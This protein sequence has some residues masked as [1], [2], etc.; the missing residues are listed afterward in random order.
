[1]DEVDQEFPPLWE[2]AASNGLKTGVFGSLLTHEMPKSLENYAFYVPEVFAN[3][4]STHPSYLS[5]FQGF[6]LAMSRA[7]ARNV[8]KKIDWSSAR[9]F[10]TKSFDLGLTLRTSLDIG[11]QLISEQLNSHHKTRRRTYQSTLGFDIFMKQLQ[12]FKPDLVTFFTNHVAATMHRYW[13]ASFP[14][15]YSDFQLLPTWVST[16][17]DEID[18]AMHKTDEMLARLVNFVNQNSEYALY[19]IT[20]MGQAAFQAKPT[21]AFL[22]IADLPKFMARLGV[23][24]SE[25]EQRPAMAPHYSVVVTPNKLDRL[26]DRSSKLMMNGKPIEFRERE[27]G[28][29]HIDFMY[30]GY[31]GPASVELDGVKI[32]FA[33]IGI[34]NTEHEDGV[35]LTADHI[36]QGVMLIY[37]LKQTTSNRE[38]TQI[39]TLDITPSILDNF[40]I[41]IPDYMNRT[42]NLIAA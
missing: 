18:F 21:K 20:S 9:E 42:P 5:S 38:R 22:T 41:S 7:S 1:L 35:Y 13:A 23:E 40:S 16:F 11:G 26:R 31:Q 36:P 12:I 2:L 32:S 29:F 28:F 25:Y 19:V 27:D 37:N 17:R 39:S 15:D 30:Q 14:N 33:E 24:A 34:V 10:V 3:E 4:A 6:N 8:S